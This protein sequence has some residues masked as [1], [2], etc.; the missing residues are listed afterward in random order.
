MQKLTPKD[1]SSPDLTEENIRQLGELFPEILADGTIDFEA[2]RGILGDHV[3]GREERYSF[4]WHGKALARRIAQAPSAGTL[5][6]CP[7]ASVGWGTSKNLFIEGDNLEVLKLLQKPYHRK[8]KMIYID[9][10]YNTGN[11]FIYPDRFGDSLGTYMRFTGQVDE[12]GMKLS[13]NA[14]T[15]GRYH[16]NWLNMMYPRLRLA[17]N[18]MRDDGLM[19]VSIDDH[20]SHNLRHLMDEVFGP[21]NFMAA[22]AW[23]KRYTRSNNA[24]AFYSLKDTILVYRRSD[25]LEH[26]REARTA[27]ADEGY[28]N[29]DG[30]PRGPWMTSSYVNPATREKRPN[31]VYPITAPDGRVVEHP[32]HAWKNSEEEYRRHEQENRL[33][34]GS[35]GQAKFPRK[36]LYLSE[37]KGMVPVDIWDHQ[38]TGTTDEG[39][40]EVKA[41]FD[42]E[43]VFDNPKP[44]R[45]IRRMLGLSTEGHGEEIVLDFFAGSASTGDAVMQQNHADGGDR[46]YILVQLPEPVDDDRFGTIAGVSMARLRRAAAALDGPD[47]GFNVFRLSSSNIKPWDA[48]FDALDDALLHAIDN[49]RDGRSRDDVLYEL[50]LKYGLDLATPIDERTLA[51]KAVFVIDGGALVVCL[52]A[53]ITLEVV[54]GIAALK[55]E[56][57][58]RVMRVVFKD[59][60]FLDDVVK[61]NTVQLLRQHGVDDVKSL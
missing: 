36:K 3:D 38:S 44:T 25:T 57:Q 50:L 2:L 7:D 11:E 16:T 56:L 29:P 51:G 52:D 6:P 26:L 17:R 21:E 18:L 41:L 24:K 61:A 20:E 32:T 60:G 35:D 27:K 12:R 45:L 49:I 46:R 28:S 43:A 59:A 1:G 19:F 53:G 55:R 14:E 47:P 8:V 22:I 13:A 10:P 37:A 30:D 31:L 15:A 39:G 42:G 5:L 48:E 58:P 33:W 34:W 23:E 54:E 9:P 40:L 4:S